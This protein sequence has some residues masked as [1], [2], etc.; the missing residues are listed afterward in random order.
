MTEI[1]IVLAAQSVISQFEDTGN[2]IASLLHNKSVVVL[3]YDYENTGS[4][5]EL[6]EIIHSH[7]SSVRKGTRL[8]SVGLMFHTAEDATLRC[9]SKDPVRSTV[10]GNDATFDDFRH[11]VHVLGIFYQIDAFD[12]ISCNVVQHATS[13]VLARLN[14]GGV[15]VNASI[16]RTGHALDGTGV[17]GQ[18]AAGGYNKGG[19]DDWVL[20]MGNVDLVGR[21]FNPKITKVHVTLNLKNNVA[22]DIEIV[23]NRNC[24]QNGYPTRDKCIPEQ[25]TI[26]GKVV[27]KN[28]RRPRQ[29]SSA[30][31]PGLT[32]R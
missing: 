28:C 30:G 1:R 2:Y 23:S 14:Y 8:L 22:R 9:F 18:A 25:V 24:T 29:V 32:Q 12:L 27:C 16:N 13:N 21:Y 6:V 26:S 17:T 20:E 11:F 10:N 15:R 31:V 19:G 5:L 7:M 4:Y 3:P